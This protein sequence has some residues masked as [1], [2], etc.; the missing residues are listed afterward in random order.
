MATTFAVSYEQR[1]IVVENCQNG[2]NER[3]LL[4][5]IQNINVGALDRA[6]HVAGGGGWRLAGGG[7]W[8]ERSQRGTKGDKSQGQEPC[9][10][11]QQSSSLLRSAR[12]PGL[13][14]RS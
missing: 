11:L 8:D 5:A 9:F 3:V 14:L 4:V 1:P 13:F 6:L 7:R 12:I 2:V 10:D